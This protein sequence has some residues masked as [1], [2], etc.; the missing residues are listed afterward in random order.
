MKFDIRELLR[1]AREDDVSDIHLK[2]GAPP[3]LRKDG[4]LM[5]VKDI[6]ALTSEDL[7]NVVKVMTDEKQRKTLEKMKG[8]DLS[9]IHI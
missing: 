3:V 4:R 6:P 7:W 8:L 5:P 2:V 9:L 1:S